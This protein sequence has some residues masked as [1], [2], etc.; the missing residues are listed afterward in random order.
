MKGVEKIKDESN[1]FYTGKS[2]KMFKIS[3]KVI[4]WYGERR[5]T[6]KGGAICFKMSLKKRIVVHFTELT[7]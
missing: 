1:W 4:V 2:K 3:L 5:F 7:F 6:F